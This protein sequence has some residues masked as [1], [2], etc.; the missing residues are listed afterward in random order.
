MDVEIS[1]DGGASYTSSAHEVQTTIA[2]TDEVLTCGGAADTWGRAWTAGNFS[3]ANFR[4]RLTFTD[5]GGT[6]WY[7]ELDHVQ[8]NVYYTEEV[9]GG[10][11]PVPGRDVLPYKKGIQ[12]VALKNGDSLYMKKNLSE[13]YVPDALGIYFDSQLGND[14]NAGTFSS[15]Y[16]TISKLQ[17]LITAHTVTAGTTVYL[18]CGSR[19]DGTTLTIDHSGTSGDHIRFRPYGTGAAP[20]LTGLK[21]ISGSWTQAGNHWTK[22]DASL[23]ASM[24]IVVRSSPTA[25][26]TFQEILPFVF[27][28]GV[29]YNVSKFPNA[30]RAYHT[31]SAVSSDGYSYFD[32]IIGWADGYWTGAEVM[33]NSVNWGM[34]RR[35]VSSYTSGRF[36]LTP[37]SYGATAESYSYM[38]F[39]SNPCFFITNHYNAQDNYGE[40]TYNYSTKTIDIY[41]ATSINS[42]AIYAPVQDYVIKID[43][44]DYIDI[45]GLD[46]RSGIIAGIY[47]YQSDN[48]NIDL[49]MQGF[50]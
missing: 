9:G 36:N 41:S 46:I 15:P 37:G 13:V 5:A 28:D 12:L 6:P 32:C 22:T 3:N 4:L 50:L 26:W 2:F 48:I 31:I 21:N 18:K 39:P 20:I 17:T 38:G 1:W 16:Q 30:A 19:W 27:I 29:P 14:G 43:N 45:S 10:Y 25:Y 7:S 47:V 23:P 24:S 40:W 49:V 8:V 42:K 34:S 35:T 44:A 33:Y 11:S